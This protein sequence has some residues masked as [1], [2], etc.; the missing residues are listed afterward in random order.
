VS[1]WLRAAIR[2]PADR[3]AAAGDVEQLLGARQ[4]ADHPRP[5]TPMDR[6]HRRLQAEVDEIRARKDLSDDGRRRQLAKVTDRAQR[7]MRAL[8]RQ[9]AED[10]ERRK[11]ELLAT[12]F[13]T[14]S[15]DATA[16]VSYRDAMDR[17]GQLKTPEEATQLLAQARMVGDEPLGRAVAMRVLDQAMNR[18]LIGGQAWA[19]LLN[20][21]AA[22]QP[23]HVDQALTELSALVDAP[24]GIARSL[25]Y[26]LATPS[27]L[28][29]QDLVSLAV[30]ADRH[31]DEDQLPETF[32][33]RLYRR[34]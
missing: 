16:I 27:E 8:S 19:E 29:G 32:V 18:G 21:W 15:R 25:A 26:S 2:T 4:P 31:P 3:R 34:S 6:L 10:A 22:T 30:A 11:A 13:G 7:E 17:A 24:G 28:D 33:D 9:A 1:D 23:P 20:E 14:P 12:I 5:D